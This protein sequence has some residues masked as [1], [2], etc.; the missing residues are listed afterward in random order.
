MAYD[1]AE[2]SPVAAPPGPLISDWDARKAATFGRAPPAL[3]P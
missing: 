2:V 1:A 3:P